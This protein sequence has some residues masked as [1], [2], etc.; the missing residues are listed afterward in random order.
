MDPMDWAKESYDLAKDN[1]YVGIKSG[2]VVTAEYIEKNTALAENRIV[3]A[4][5]RLAH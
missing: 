2:D 1:V 3:L 5:Y 4:G